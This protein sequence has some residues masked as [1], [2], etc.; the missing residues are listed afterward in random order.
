MRKLEGY[1]RGLQ[2]AGWVCVD[3]GKDGKGVWVHPALGGLEKP[4][5]LKEA[6]V[7]EFGKDWATSTTR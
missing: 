1:I 3:P 7:S 2:I 6:V 5:S 4:H